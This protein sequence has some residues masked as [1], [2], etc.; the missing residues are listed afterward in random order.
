MI[1]RNHFTARRGIAALLLICAAI[2][3]PRLSLADS[4]TF[5]T[6]TIHLH[7]EPYVQT[8]FFDILMSDSADSNTTGGAGNLP[9]DETGVTNTNGSDLVTAITAEV[10]TSG[11]GITFI[12]ADDNTDVG[13]VNA[14]P[15]LYATN[16]SVTFPTTANLISNQ[17]ANWNDIPN[18]SGTTVVAGTPLGLLRVEY[19]IDPNTIGV[20]P[21][22][23]LDNMMDPAFGAVW[24]DSVPN[25]NDPLFANGSITV[26]PEPSSWILAGMS[27]CALLAFRR[28][29]RPGQAHRHRRLHPLA[30]PSARLASNVAALSSPNGCPKAKS[31]LLPWL[32]FAAAAAVLSALPATGRGGEIFVDNGATVG[33][34]TT[35]W[36]TLNSS[37]ITG[38]TYSAGIAVSDGACLSRTRTATA[39]AGSASTTPT[40]R[41]STPN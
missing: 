37:L 16:S 38:L 7:S 20:F 6:P 27:L 26:T 13:A 28:L 17:D 10:V 25:P 9:Y 22:T 32:A 12:G 33:A 24:G 14:E 5:L 21:L 23:Q 11:T 36:T 31:V 29:A 30:N 1:T 34:Y 18:N 40:A 3:F 4:I 19:T 15:Y 35:G 41:R 39:M 8:G 2:A